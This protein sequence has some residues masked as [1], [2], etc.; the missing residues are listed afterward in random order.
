MTTV[1][2]R[3]L[4]LAFL[5]AS[6]A[7]V[8][9]CKSSGV[10]AATSNVDISPEAPTMNERF[11]S[12]NPRLC[13]QLMTPPTPAQ[14]KVLVQCDHESGSNPAGMNPN[15]AL[16]TDLQVQMSAPRDFQMIGTSAP[17]IDTKSQVYD[18]RGQGTSW[19]CQPVAGQ[20][21]TRPAGE[22]CM[23]SDAVPKGKGQCF[24][25]TFGDWKCQMTVGGGQWAF[26]VKGPTTF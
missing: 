8:S 14:A 7:A 9:G 1:N 3:T 20:G 15:F 25:T 26:P 19:M 16:V 21:G 6:L 23:R 12:R 13:A 11:A 18:L 24:K 5:A 22:N 10:S 2:Q 17:D 4:T